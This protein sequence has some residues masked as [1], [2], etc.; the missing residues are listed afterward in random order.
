M[1]IRKKY[2]IYIAKKHFQEIFLF[3][4]DKRRTQ[5]LL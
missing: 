4:L 3:I 2:Q 1:T 5:K